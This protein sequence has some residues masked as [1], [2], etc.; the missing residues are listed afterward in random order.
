MVETQTLQDTNALD[1]SYQHVM[2]MTTDDAYFDAASARAYQMIIA[3]NIFI[4]MMTTGSKSFSYRSSL[5]DNSIL[6]VDILTN[7]R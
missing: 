7:S 3:M 1:V 6:V 4:A 2:M 5:A